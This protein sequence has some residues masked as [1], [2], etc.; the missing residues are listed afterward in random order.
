MK[1]E[2]W[3]KEL[4]SNLNYWQGRPLS[5]FYYHPLYH[6]GVGKK[7]DLDFIFGK[8][9]KLPFKNL[10]KFNFFT[11][12]APFPEDSVIFFQPSRKRI[13]VASHSENK[14]LKIS[15]SPSQLTF[16]DKE[17]ELLKHLETSEFATHSAKVL[18]VGSNWVVTSFCSNS[19]SLLNIPD[20]EEYL[21]NNLNPLIME[22]LAKFYR[23]QG[24]EKIN[25]ADW[26][27]KAKRRAVG[28][29][30]EEQ[31]NKRLD[32]IEVTDATL[33]KS[34]LHF[35]LHAGNVLKDKENVVIIDWEV[36]RPG[37]VL[38]DYFDFYRRY[39]Y[40]DDREQKLFFAF[41]T[42]KGE[43]PQKLKMFFEKFEGWS[44]QFGVEGLNVK[45]FTWLYAIE[46][47]LIFW[48]NWQENRLKDKKGLES[49]IINL[50]ME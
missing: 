25:L 41:L 11:L 24:I 30:S 27:S 40:K 37:L 4:L 7:T 22:P 29:P 20:V 36:S 8:K 10:R 34:L 19:D 13:I 1:N 3:L 21:L 39:L 9:R 26:I 16:K 42:G 31:I 44:K 2:K 47:T 6:V 49:K 43:V 45:L 5:T 28:H 14:V 32:E 46:R 17:V 15:I 38:V 50:I 35:D 48:E 23:S 12:K 18:E 33:V